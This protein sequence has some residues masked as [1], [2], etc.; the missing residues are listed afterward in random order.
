MTTVFKDYKGREWRKE[1][2]NA[3]IKAIERTLE[4]EQDIKYLL[5]EQD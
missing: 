1:N 5:G 3:L 2:L 4:S